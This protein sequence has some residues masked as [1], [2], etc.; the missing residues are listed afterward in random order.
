MKKILLG[1]LVLGS[2][3]ALADFK[4][5]CASASKQFQSDSV[6]QAQSSLNHKLT[7]NIQGI[8]S[9]SNPSLKTVHTVNGSESGEFSTQTSVCVTVNASSF[10]A[11]SLK[12]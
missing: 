11:R 8:K 6:E 2:F 7:H 5:I 1:L 9:V 10:E 12:N 3:S 4:V